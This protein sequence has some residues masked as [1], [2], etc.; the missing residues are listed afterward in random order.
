MVTAAMKLKNICSL[1]EKL[2]QCIKK[3]R[4]YFVSKVPSSH[5]YGFSTSHVWM[6]KLNH[7]ESWALKN[8][9]FRSVVLEKILESPLYCKEIQPA[10]PKGSQP[11]IF[12]VR[13]DAKA[14]ASILWP[15][16]Q[17][18]DSL[19]KTLMLGK[20]EGRREG[21]GRDEMRREPHGF[22]DGNLSK[23]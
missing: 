21:G 15:L 22:N 17:R 10:N 8:W 9:C 12:T 11:W 5:S 7:K 16:V 3:Q 18:A 6:W 19:E 4:H 14:A 23:L 13:T 1:E 2:W 20:T